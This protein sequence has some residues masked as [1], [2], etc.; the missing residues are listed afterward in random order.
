MA[1]LILPTFA[2]GARAKKVLIF[3]ASSLFWLNSIKPVVVPEIDE[4][5][6]RTIKLSHGHFRLRIL[7]HSSEAFS[8]PSPISK[9]KLSAKVVNGFQPLTIFAKSS[10]SD[11][12]MGCECSSATLLFYLLFY[13]ISKQVHVQLTRLSPMH[14]FSTPWKC[15]LSLPYGFLM[16]SG[17][18]VRVHWEQIGLVTRKP[19]EQYV[20]LVQS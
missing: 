18:R 1:P 17:G 12:W 9:L 2:T 20:K 14:P 5:I 11:V 8:E 7:R 3:L 13:I 6:F 15:T 10:I 4:L 19:L 16:F